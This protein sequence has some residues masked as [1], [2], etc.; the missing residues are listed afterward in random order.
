MSELASKS[1]KLNVI[2]CFSYWALNICSDCKIEDELK[3][4]KDIFI[5]N[6]YPEQVIVD[7]IKFTV[8]GFKNK[9]FRLPWVGSASQS[10]AERIA[11]SVYCCYHAVNL[12]LI[13][14]TRV[15]FHSKHKDKLPIFKQSMLIYKFVCLCCSTYIG[16]TCQHLEVRIRQHVPSYFIKSPT[17]IRA[18]LGNGLRNW[19]AFAYHE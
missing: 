10:F 2:R 15:A 3:V 7:N 12:R 1:R 18:L 9:N 16:R 8:T 11:T 19:W 13:F 6:V 17:N 14:T 4:I 5:N